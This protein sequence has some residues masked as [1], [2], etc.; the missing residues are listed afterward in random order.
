MPRRRDV[1]EEGDENS[2]FAFQFLNELTD[3]GPEFGG[4]VMSFKGGAD[5]SLQ[6]DRMH[7]L[8][9]ALDGQSDVI[10]DTSSLQNLY[11]SLSRLTSTSERNQLQDHDMTIHLATYLYGLLHGPRSIAF[12]S[13]RCYLAMLQVFGTNSALILNS[14]FIRKILSLLTQIVTTVSQGTATT[15]VQVLTQ[16][17]VGGTQNSIQLTPDYPASQMQ[18]VNPSQKPRRKRT[19]VPGDDDVVAADWKEAY[20]TMLLTVKEFESEVLISIFDADLVVSILETMAQLPGK[21]LSGPLKRKGLVKSPSPL[22]DSCYAVLKEAMLRNFSYE[23]YD[24]DDTADDVEPVAKTVTSQEIVL[25]QLLEALHLS[26]IYTS[27]VRVPDAV[28]LQK[29][30]LC[31]ITTSNIENVFL[32][33]LIKL[34]MCTGERRPRND[35]MVAACKAGVILITCVTDEHLVEVHNYLTQQLSISSLVYHRLFAVEIAYGILKNDETFKGLSDSQ[36]QAVI[37]I[38]FTAVNDTAA[39]VRSKALTNLS[40]VMQVIG[41]ADSIIR[42]AVSAYLTHIKS[43]AVDSSV[44][45]PAQQVSPVAEE[46]ITPVGSNISCSPGLAAIPATEMDLLVAS[47][48]ARTREEKALVRKAAIDLLLQFFEHM[49]VEAGPVMTTVTELMDI[50]LEPSV[51]VRRQAVLCAWSMIVHI[52]DISVRSNMMGGILQ[53]FCYETEEFVTK[54]MLQSV[55]VLILTPLAT[56]DGDL[57]P[58]DVWALTGALTDA[59]LSSL[60]KMCCKLLEDGDID[61]KIVKSLVRRIEEKPSCKEAWSILSVV[62]GKFKHKINTAVVYKSF[63]TLKGNFGSSDINDH[64]VLQHVCSL[65]PRVTNSEKEKKNEAL[66][67]DRRE[68]VQTIESLLLS[69]RC[70][71]NL[72]D[73]SVRCYVE[74]INNTSVTTRITIMF[75]ELVFALLYNLLTDS[76]VKPIPTAAQKAGL[77]GVTLSELPT[78]LCVMGSFLLVTSKAESSSG[79]ATRS[80]DNCSDQLH[81][82]ICA[83]CS[84]SNPQLDIP[85]QVVRHAYLCQVKMCIISKVK[86]KKGVP[87]LLKGLD[88]SEMSIRTTCLNGLADLSVKYPGTVD[89]YLPNLAALLSDI[90]VRVRLTAATLITQLLGESFLKPRPFLMYEILTLIADPIDSVASLARYSLLKIMLPKDPYLIVNN[91]KE[92]PFV[93]NNYPFHQKYNKHVVQINRL[94]GDQHRFTRIQLIRFC[95]SQIGTE[96]DILRVHEQL[97][98]ILEMCSSEGHGGVQLNIGCCEGVA[99]F[100]DVVQVLLS[101]EMHLAGRSLE[102]SKQ[103]SISTQ[104]QSDSMDPIQAEDEEEQSALKKAL[105]IAAIK[106]RVKSVV[107]PILVGVSSRLRQL[108]SPLQRDLVHYAAYVMQEY[109]RDIDD[110]VSDPLLKKDIL[111]TLEETRRARGGKRTLGQLIKTNTLPPAPSTPGKSPGMMSRGSKTPLRNS[112][113]PGRLNTP[114]VTPVVKKRKTRSSDDVGDCKE[115]EVP[116]S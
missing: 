44:A 2:E 86:C 57:T 29:A 60:G 78:A 24:H 37:K 95:C 3:Q 11:E 89:K 4:V 45:P 35:P 59:H 116:A 54:T 18:H 28:L 74:M 34:F 109:E 64:T 98:E 40:K 6:S 75:S 105:W 113:T 85:E 20:E 66:G 80:V 32:V 16:E 88:H 5:L 43:T 21:E 68:I 22:I 87:L 93:L 39:I 12:A 90:D 49:V 48:V 42:G 104:P 36:A 63:F 56:A 31:L 26:C 51:L 10:F 58:D 69:L 47:V 108:R 53:N 17:S 76:C 112:L 1:Q 106:Q 15:A 97:H 77:S 82:M 55:Q 71:P 107:C 25:P 62:A 83:I 13:A 38:L 14:F 19:K 50:K 23:V 111:T 9:A 7:I 102:S 100:K 115:N 67:K 33:R 61:S 73:A 96:K 41:A 72:V 46:V 103:K 52:T 99:V 114:N 84:S 65:L 27:Q 81:Q 70:H 92:L 101:H 30:A 91:V 8:A 79:S 94:C 110:F